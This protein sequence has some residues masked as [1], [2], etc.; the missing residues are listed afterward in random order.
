MTSDLSAYGV[1]WL[2]P[3]AVVFYAALRVIDYINAGHYHDTPKK[4]SAPQRL[5]SNQQGRTNNDHHKRGDAA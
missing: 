3:I 5:D 4:H 1:V 2:L